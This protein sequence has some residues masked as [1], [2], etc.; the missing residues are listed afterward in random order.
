MQAVSASPTGSSAATTAPKA[1][2]RMPSASGTAVNSAV[3]KS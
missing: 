1:T 3:L 2:S